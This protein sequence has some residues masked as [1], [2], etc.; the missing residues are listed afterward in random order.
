MSLRLRTGNI[1][2]AYAGYEAL[3]RDYIGAKQQGA[4]RFAGAFAPK[5]QAGL[6]F[7]DLVIRAFALPGFARLAI[8]RDIA[9]RL[10][11]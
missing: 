6:F 8:G 9:D 4:E 5:T 2:K 1:Q 3:L 11:L 10:D 7:H